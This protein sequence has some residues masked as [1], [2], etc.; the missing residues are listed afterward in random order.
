MEKGFY[1][2]Y[3]KCCQEF[4]SNNRM[5][6]K[7]LTLTLN[8]NKYKGGGFI[9]CPKCADY[10]AE[11]KYKQDSLI[12]NRYCPHPFPII[13]CYNLNCKCIKPPFILKKIQ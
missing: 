1:Y 2:G 5:T 10:L 4:F 13:Y 11:N 9:P 12:K 3:P 7:D 6:K 8:Q